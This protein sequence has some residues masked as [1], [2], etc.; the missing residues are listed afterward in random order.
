MA[1]EFAFED[2]EDGGCWRGDLKTGK[3]AESRRRAAG[4]LLWVVKDLAT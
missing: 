2:Q 1:V 4:L 3:R